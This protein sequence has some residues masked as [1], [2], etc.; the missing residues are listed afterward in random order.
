MSEWADRRRAFGS[1]AELYDRARPGYPDAQMA[2]VL[3][4]RVAETDG[5]RVLL[6]HGPPADE[7]AAEVLRT[8]HER[9]APQVWQDQKPVQ[10]PDLVWAEADDQ[11]AL[12]DGESRLY[13]WVRTQTVE[14]YL[15]YLS[16]HSIYVLLDAA[17][18][19]ALFDDI[20]AGLGD[21][22]VSDV[23]TMLYLARRATGSGQ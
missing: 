20:R 18:R 15:D 23:D 5:A 7:A 12:A 9:H 3:R 2:D 16:T 13:T 10:P 11:P 4:A 1:V 19:E 17:V 22:I 6:E 8:A 21:R 14:E